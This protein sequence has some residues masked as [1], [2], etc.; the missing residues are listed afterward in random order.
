M[1]RIKYIIFASILILFQLFT[2]VLA[3]WNNYRDYETVLIPGQRIAELLDSPVDEIFVFTYNGNENEWSQITIQIDEKDDGVDYFITPN[4]LLDPN[5]EI[6]F[7]AKDAGDK[8]LPF[9]WIDD[10]NSLLFSRYE[11]EVRDP[12]E[13]GKKKYVYV[14]RSTTWLNDPELPVYM[15]YVPSVSGHSDTVKT[16]GYTLGHNSRGVPDYWKVPVVAGG[17]GIDFLDRQ[18]ARIKGKYSYSIFSYNFSLNENDLDVDGN[19]QYKTGP[20]RTIRDI[21]YKVD[22][23]GLM[24]VTVGTF[25]YQFFPYRIVAYGTNKSLGSDYGIKLIRQSFDLNVNADGMKFNDP[26]NIYINIDGVRENVG[27]PVYPKPELNWYMISGSPGTIVMIN[28][29]EILT[30]STAS[31]Y[32][33]D[34]SNGGTVDGTGDTGDGKSYGDAGILF[35]G[36][37]IQGKFSIPYVTYFLPADLSREIGP[38]VVD[39]YVNPLINSS[40]S[41]GYL[42]PIELTVSMPDTTCP[43]GQ[44]MSIPIKIGDL[45]EQEIT[46]SLLIINYDPQILSADSVSTL[47]SLVEYW[48]QPVVDLVGDS[49][50]IYLQGSTALL[51]SGVLLYL[52]VTAVGEEDQSSLLQ[53]SNVEFNQ[54]NP[55]AL[56][57]DGSCTITAPPE[58]SISMPNT[59]TAV[60]SKIIIP[61]KIG[62]V[63]NMNVTSCRLEIQYSKFV[64]FADSVS[65]LG[66]KTQDWHMNIDYNIGL[67]DIE[68]NG[69]IPLTGES[70]LLNIHFKVVSS[71]GQT[72]ELHFKEAVLN[73]G[74]PVL[75]PQDGQVTVL[76]LPQQEILVSI[77]DKTVPWGNLLQIP[78]RISSLTNLNI[79]NYRMN[80]SFDNTVLTFSGID[81]SGSISEVWNA[82]IIWDNGDNIVMTAYGNIPLQGEGD[83]IYLNFDVI[84][85][86]GT[87]SPIHFESMTVSSSEVN[88]S[89]RDGM[90]HIEGAV[91]VELSSFIA[92]RRAKSVILSWK[93][94]TE[95]NNYGF[96]I[97][98]K[99]KNSTEWET[100]GFRK[101]AGTTT[102]PQFYQFIDQEIKTGFWQ[103][104]LNQIDFDGAITFSQ[105][106]EIDVSTASRLVLHQNY[107]NPFNSSTTI[108]FELAEDGKEVSVLIYNLRGNLIKKL[109]DNEIQNAGFYQIVWN[110]TDNTRNQVSSGIYYYQ[111]QVGDFKISKKMVLIE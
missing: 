98:R 48:D 77:P 53:F 33:Y 93:T 65:I 18:K 66:T 56:P 61:V 102:S 109:V 88:I 15:N 21:K 101:G 42:A 19:I 49:I 71:S 47:N 70:T 39:Q 67:L 55:V 87:F 6:L 81:N 29:F 22:F 106:I 40:T 54:G 82:P 73:N 76:T 72:S 32:Y 16:V 84:G 8:A 34:H 50:E 12:L 23:L 108:S 90:V 63:T 86:S 14:Y 58:V 10:D 60:N 44:T 91:P 51:D 79:Y 111:V 52:T 78:I 37:K 28:E 4:N 13:T 103:Y 46:S 35:Q 27:K 96:N 94:E 5:D 17:N 105:S 62:D 45:K 99:E 31:F 2:S 1:I 85:S 59:S 74:V 97:Q 38:I 9:Q 43:K 36:S 83:L 24:T 107:P 26:T 69:Q 20:I 57:A 3:N 80:L 41:Q 92:E 64:L 110:G 100:I 95:S 68:L 75:I 30:N 7:M 11:I 25:K 89:T 104:R